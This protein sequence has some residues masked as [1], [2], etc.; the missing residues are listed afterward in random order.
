[1]G[2]RERSLDDYLEDVR[3]IRATMLHADERLHV[4]PWFFFTIAALVALGILTHALIGATLPLTTA[5]LTIWLPVFLLAGVAEIAAWMAVGRE[6]GLPWLSRPFARFLATVSGIMIAVIALGLAALYAGYPVPGTVLILAGSV[7]HAYS[8][9]APRAAI[10]TGWALLIPGI[11]LLVSG[12]SATAASI[13]AGLL[14][15]VGFVVVGFAERRSRARH[16]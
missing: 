2:V 4:P 14:V 8:S 11:G 15:C 3:Q 12:I 9:Y 13:A 6:E 5:L 1:M 16:G 10:W 7:F